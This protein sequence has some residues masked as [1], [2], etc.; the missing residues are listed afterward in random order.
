VGRLA[1]LSS[2]GCRR[3]RRTI[4]HRVPRRLHD[5]ANARFQGIRRALSGDACRDNGR[6]RV[7]HWLVR[8]RC[9][10]RSHGRI[11]RVDHAERA[12]GTT[13]DDDYLYNT[14]PALVFRG[15]SKRIRIRGCTFISCTPFEIISNNSQAE[16]EFTDNLVLNAP[17]ALVPPSIGYIAGNR[18]INDSY[19]A[20]RS[21]AM[22]PQGFVERLRIGR[23]EHVAIDRAGRIAQELHL[24]LLATLTSGRVGYRGAGTVANVQAVPAVVGAAIGA[25]TDKDR[26][27][28]VFWNLDRQKAVLFGE[29]G[30][31][32]GS[33]LEALFIKDRQERIEEGLAQ[34]NSLDLDRQPLTFLGLDAEVV[35]VLVL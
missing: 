31:I 32:N 21:H 7:V 12:P 28:A 27:I 10:V 35:R 33:Q 29:H 6:A 13:T 22:Y 4:G 8:T 17:N 1:I 34:A 25:L 30:V 19:V 26:V 23:H 2:T 18:F 20:T 11:D 5:R 16:F 9:G 15:V 14:K 3:H 24:H